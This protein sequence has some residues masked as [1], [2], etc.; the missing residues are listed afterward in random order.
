MPRMYE[1]SY[2]EEQTFV[3][4]TVTGSKTYFG[5]TSSV[6]TQGR[7]PDGVFGRLFAISVFPNAESVVTAA[8]AEDIMIFLSTAI[9]KLRVG[10]RK[11]GQ[12]PV[13]SLPAG[14]VHAHGNSAA[15]DVWFATNG[16]DSRRLVAEVPIGALDMVECEIVY[17]TTARAAN[18]KV[19]VTLHV[20]VEEKG[21]GE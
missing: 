15:G 21:K 4:A 20:I 11:V 12:F 8:K 17:P 6:L 13:S 5:P 1:T 2:T 18:L 10:D 14:G 3:A 16:A 7:L 9:L 19:N